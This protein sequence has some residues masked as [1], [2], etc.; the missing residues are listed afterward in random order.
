[1]LI[2]MGL[3]FGVLCMRGFM[4]RNGEAR[5]FMPHEAHTPLVESEGGARE[6]TSLASS[7]V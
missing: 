1:V 7:T 5:T 2:G 4:M 3:I 6:L